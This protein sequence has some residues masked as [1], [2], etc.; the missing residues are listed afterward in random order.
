MQA[1]VTSDEDIFAVK[2]INLYG[3]VQSLVKGSPVFREIPI[4]G[5]PFDQDVFV[6]GMIDEIRCDTDWFNFDIFE[7]KT[8]ISRSLPSQAQKDTHKMQVLLYKKLFDDLVMGITTKQTI[9]KHLKLDLGRPL[10]DDVRRHCKQTQSRQPSDYASLDALLDCLGELMQSVPCISQTFIEYCHQESHETIG[11][12]AITPD[13]DWLNAT[14]F[15]YVTFWRGEREARGV[16]IEDAW[17][18]GRC[19]FADVCEWRQKKQEEYSSKNRMKHKIG[20]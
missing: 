3:A 13:A 8:R 19:D 10:G 14:F 6:I 4:F 1:K 12:E 9:K 5:A 11:I 17:K 2:V 20:T 16:D 15:D 18:C 7:F